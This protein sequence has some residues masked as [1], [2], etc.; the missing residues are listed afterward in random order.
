[1]NRLPVESEAIASFGYDAEKATLDVEFHSGHVYRYFMVP[2]S[3]FADFEEAPSKGTFFARH[4][5]PGG[6]PY[7]KLE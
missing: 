1:M 7:T 2:A 5:R 4:I 6:F 3:V